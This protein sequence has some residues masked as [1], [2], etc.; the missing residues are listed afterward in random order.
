MSKDL[1]KK[2]KILAIFIGI[3]GALGCLIMAFA[4]LSNKNYAV[5]IAWIFLAIGCVLLILPLSAVGSLIGDM[6]EQREKMQ[7]LSDKMAKLS[8]QGGETPADKF[9]PSGRIKIQKF[10]QTTMR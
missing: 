9:S 1:G 4:N 2:I 10:P 5:L 7:I 6:A 8:R 3:I